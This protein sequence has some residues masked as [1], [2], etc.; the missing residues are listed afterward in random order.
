MKEE[1]DVQLRRQGDALRTRFIRGIEKI[2]CKV[3]F[4]MRGTFHDFKSQFADY[5]CYWQSKARK[6]EAI[7]DIRIQ[8]DALCSAIKVLESG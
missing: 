5:S 1:C 2:Q 8:A 3:G 7:I 6:L 4:Q